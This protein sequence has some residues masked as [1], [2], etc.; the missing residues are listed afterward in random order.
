VH[1]SWALCVHQLEHADPI[2]HIG[3]STTSLTRSVLSTVT[4]KTKHLKQL[5]TETVFAVALTAQALSFVLHY[6]WLGQI[7]A[8]TDTAQSWSP[9]SVSV[10][11]SI[12]APHQATITKPVTSKIQYRRDKRT[13]IPTQSRNSS[14]TQAEAHQH[15]T[16][17]NT[18]CQRSIRHTQTWVMEDICFARGQKYFMLTQHLII[19]AAWPV[20]WEGVIRRMLTC[21][22]RSTLVE[23]LHKGRISCWRSFLSSSQPL[24]EI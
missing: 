21:L 10:Q 20:Q 2:C 17:D 11:R 13:S 24:N 4:L 3:E 5:Q 7:I 14:R 6:S 22:W 12:P 16:S 9:H 8:T 23:V 15:H 19:T 18:G 1:W